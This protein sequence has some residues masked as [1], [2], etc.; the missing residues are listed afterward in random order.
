MLIGQAIHSFLDQNEN[1]FPTKHLSLID[2]IQFPPISESLEENLVLAL[3]NRYDMVAIGKSKSFEGLE[4]QKM[5]KENTQPIEQGEEP[6]PIGQATMQEDGS[7]ILQLWAETD[8]DASGQAIFTYSPTDE[9]YASI[10]EHIGCLKVGE[11]K[12]VFPW[13][14][15]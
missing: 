13:P 11:T 10:L 3:D 12:L 6:Q 4:Q 15:E 1:V 2:S 5:N 9:D 8:D 7:I 14:D